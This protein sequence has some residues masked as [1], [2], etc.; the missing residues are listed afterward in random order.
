MSIFLEGK[1]TKE[2]LFNRIV[3]IMK[4]AGWKNISSAPTTEF[5]VMQSTG[6]LGD[7]N[8]VFQMRPRAVNG[9]DNTDI[10]TNTTSLMTYRLI[11]GYTPSET[12]GTAG[13]FERPNEAWRHLHI[14]AGAMNPQVEL[15][16]WYSVNKNRVIFVIYPPESLNLQPTAFYI[17]EPITY[18][19]EPN[20]KGVIAMTTYYS[21][22]S[23]Q[24]HI[25][26]EVAELPSLTASKALTNIFTL[27]PKSPNSAGIHTPFE[28]MFGDAAVGIRG[29]I[30]SLYFLPTN[31]INDGDILKFGSKRYRAVV[32]A[33]YSNNSFP[34]NT[35]IIQ[36]S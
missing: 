2:E 22:F 18:T 3:D 29:K 23:N 35:F 30:D 9:A 5:A 32:F 10:G 17:G 11:N 15:K 16:Y 21:S 13:T 25:S 14:G 31:S 19:S 12:T 28:L 36:I 8:L 27:P 33:V 1:C 20:S 24:V 6:E 7:K 34:T 26:D 4:S